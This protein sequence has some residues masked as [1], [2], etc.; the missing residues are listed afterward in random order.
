MADDDFDDK[1]ILGIDTF[2]DNFKTTGYFNCQQRVSTANFIYEL[3]TT[4]VLT[5]TKKL[6]IELA[7]MK[8]LALTKTYLR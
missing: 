6:E 2:N 3:Q 1:T 8:K 7:L 4:F 5:L